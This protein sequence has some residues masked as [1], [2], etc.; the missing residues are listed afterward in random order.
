MAKLCNWERMIGQEVVDNVPPKKIKTMTAAEFKRLHCNKL[1]LKRGFAK[2]SKASHLKG[3][4]LR[5]LSDSWIK[6]TNSNPG[7][8][9]KEKNALPC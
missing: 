6:R 4:D 5:K 3:A 1:A 8:M 7:D 9:W 2:F